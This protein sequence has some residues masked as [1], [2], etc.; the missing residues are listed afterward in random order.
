MPLSRTDRVLFWIALK[1]VVVAFYLHQAWRWVFPIRA[2]RTLDGGTVNYQTTI[3]HDR[4]GTV[5]M[6]PFALGLPLYVWVRRISSRGWQGVTRLLVLPLWY[7]TPKD[8]PPF[9]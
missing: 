5:V 3:W 7:G 9:G 6:L 4:I 1:L 2:Y 8:G